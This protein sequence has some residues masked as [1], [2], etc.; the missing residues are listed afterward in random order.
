MNKANTEIRRAAK[1]A[2]V[3]LSDIAAAV[4]CD[5]QRLTKWLRDG[6]PA[7]VKPRIMEYISAKAAAGASGN[8][9]ATT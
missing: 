7:N 1:K 6:L 8:E 3:S 5:E 4:G 2:G 9:K